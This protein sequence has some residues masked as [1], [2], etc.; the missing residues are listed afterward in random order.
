[1]VGMSSSIAQIENEWSTLFPGS[2]F[3]Y[4]FIAENI[5]RCYRQEAK[6]YTAFKHFAGIAILTGCRGVYGLVGFAQSPRTSAVCLRQVLGRAVDECQGFACPA[7]AYD[8]CIIKSTI[9]TKAT[10]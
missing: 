6:E 5:A 3:Q 7:M 2:V 9:C 8:A 10:C 4:E 1:P